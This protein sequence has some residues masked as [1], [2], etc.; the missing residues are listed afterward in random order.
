MRQRK[1]RVRVDHRVKI[2]DW[3]KIMCDKERNAIPVKHSEV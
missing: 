1:D 2:E 3:V